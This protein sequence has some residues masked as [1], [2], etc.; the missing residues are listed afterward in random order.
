MLKKTNKESAYKQIKDHPNPTV[1]CKNCGRKF[2]GKFCPDCG[3]SIKEFE[4]PFSFL[5]IDL[6]GNIFAFDT[7]FRK[8][9]INVLARPGHLTF[10]YLKGHRARYMP[11]FRFYVFISFIFFVLLSVAVKKN[12]EYQDKIKTKIDSA[13]AE[14]IQERQLDSSIIA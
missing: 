6:T 4:K 1:V 7:R 2:T 5:I 12:V 11:P 3:Q 9:F 8:T 14:N 10:D 13:L